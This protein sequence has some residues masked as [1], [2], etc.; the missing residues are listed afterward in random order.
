MTHCKELDIDVIL[1][2]TF[3]NPLK[4][5]GL[6]WRSRGWD[7]TLSVFGW[8]PGFDPWLG[9]PIQLK[10]PQPQLKNPMAG[11]PTRCNEEQGSCVRWLAPST[12]KY[13]NKYVFF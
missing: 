6:P 8:G 11:D 9:P 2:L 7:S 5:Q 1:I 10:I 13:V 4:M 12:A 3:C